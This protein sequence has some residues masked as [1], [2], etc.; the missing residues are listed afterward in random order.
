MLPV[1]PCMCHQVHACDT[2]DCNFKSGTLRAGFDDAKA[3][4]RSEGDAALAQ[5]HCLPACEERR[6]LEM[7][8]D[9]V[10]KRIF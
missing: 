9:Y 3:L 6:S 5:L 4:A 1:V 10:L 2:H 8:V 7:M